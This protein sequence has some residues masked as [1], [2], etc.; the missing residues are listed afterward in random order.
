MKLI[1]IIAISL[2]RT[3]RQALPYTTMTIIKKI[4]A[5]KL[6]RVQVPL[7]YYTFT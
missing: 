4:L 6:F 2:F 3:D 5:P 7:E 1:F